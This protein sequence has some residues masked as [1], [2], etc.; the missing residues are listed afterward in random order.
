M[1]RKGCAMLDL[2]LSFVASVERDPNALAIVDGDLRLTYAEWY[3]RI[4]SIVASLEALGLKPG[5]HVVTALQNR[6]EAAT[7]HWACQ[8]AGIIITPVNWRATADDLDFFCQDA[9]AKA[10]VYEDVSVEA[11]RGCKAAC[12]LVDMRGIA[13][14]LARD[15]PNA[16]PRV[17]AE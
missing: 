9:E 3:R 7:L 2:G 16:Q 10:L 5:D 12:P 4:S 14:W 17:D 11:V 13:G 6:W 1:P 8:F 15:V